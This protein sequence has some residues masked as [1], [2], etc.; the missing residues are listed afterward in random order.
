MQHKPHVGFINSHSERIGGDHHADAVID[1][2]LLAV[3]PG[4][5]SHTGMVAPHREP[6]VFQIQIQL[7]HAFP[8]GA[9]N[10]S[11]VLPVF[12][13]IAPDLLLFIPDSAHSKIQI[14]PV[15]SGDSNV[16]PLQ[17]Q[18][19]KNILPDPLCSR[20]RKSSYDRPPGKAADKGENPHIAGPE[21]LSP[22]R[23]TVGLVHRQHRQL[24]MAGKIQKP[25]RLQT[26]RRHIDDFITA[27][28]SQLQRPGDLI[29]RQ[30][31][32]DIS[33][34]HARLV[35]RLNLIC[36]QGNQRRHHNGN[37]GHQKGRKLITQGFSR[38]RG[39][40][41]QHILA[42]QDAVDDLFLPRPERVIA[43]VSFKGLFFILII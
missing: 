31:A 30:G 14:F 6:G 22:L 12:L 43:E 5:T 11:A 2:I 28:R 8:G 34:M 23:N 21:I 24:R 19:R 26:F 33:R 25:G 38:A 39:H 36:H 3:F 35:Q 17:R 42:G 32:V 40:D 16:R 9:V 41:S 7:V 18:R 37:A 29:L 10:N 4:I 15:K 27:R 20:G 13:Q 1:E